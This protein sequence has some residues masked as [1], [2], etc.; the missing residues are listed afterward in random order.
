MREPTSEQKTAIESK[1]KTI[2]SASAGSGKTFVMIQKLVNSLIE[3][4]DIDRV[5]CVTFTKKAAAQMK[6]KLRSG[7]I[8]ALENLQADQ[9]RHLKSQLSKISTADISTIH[10]FLAKILRTYY[11]SLDIDA[12]FEL[13]ASDDSDAE[14]L[15][16][17][18][19]DSLFD[20]LYEENNPDFLFLLDRFTK[21]RSDR[22]LKK[23]I[24]EAHNSVRMLADYETL[25][26][27]WLDE[28]GEEQFKRVKEAFS[29]LA[30]D[31][32]LRL[33]AV[34]EKFENEFAFLSDNK[35]YTQIFDEMKAS[36]TVCSQRGVFHGISS[37]TS[38][39]K[40]KKKSGEDDPAGEV[41]KAF[42][43]DLDGKFKSVTKD[44]S[45]EAE[46]R[47]LLLKNTATSKAFCWL[48]LQFDREYALT[49]QEEN[50]LDYNDLEHFVLALLKDEQIK[51]EISAKYS[52]IYVDEYQDVN[53]IQEAII[54]RLGENVFFVGD[55]KQAIYGFRG[56][57]SAFFKDKFSEFK[58]EKSQ[59]LELSKNFRSTQSVLDFVNNV[60]SRIITKDFYGID[61]SPMFGGGNYPDEG[62]VAELCLYDDADEK[63]EVDGVYSVLNDSKNI[64]HTKEGLAVLALVKEELSGKHYDLEKGEFVPTKPSDICILTKKRANASTLGI[65]KALTDAGY[66]VSGVGSGDICT[67]PEV[68]NMIDIL[69]YLDNSLQ[70]I[71][72]VA[73]LM[74]P[75]GRLDE[76]ELAKIKI[77]SQNEKVSIAGGEKSRYLNFSECCKRY[78][79]V[80][81]DEIA[82]KL[83]EF[84]ARTER[85]K[86]L[87][88]LL[89]CDKIIDEILAV[90]GMEA[91]LSSGGG[92]KLKNVLSLADSARGMTVSQF[93]YKLRL[94]G[95]TIKSM[96][97][98]NSESIK[99]MTMHSSKG[100]EFPVVI[101][102][103]IAK[104]FEGGVSPIV[105]FDDKFGFAPKYYDVENKL[106][107][108][109]LLR[110]LEK[111]R[112][113]RDDVLNE[114]NLFYVAC[115]RAM[116]NLHILVSKIPKCTQDYIDN[117]SCYA[118][119]FDVDD[120]S[121]RIVVPC[122]EFSVQS[123]KRELDGK[124]DEQI[125]QAI[126]SRFMQEYS[127]SD[128]VML[129]VKSSATALLK[130]DDEQTFI[131][132][133]LFGGEG[134]TNTE[135]GTAYHRFL[136]L[137]DFSKT[138]GNAIESEIE[139][140]VSSGK[141]SDDNSRLLNAVQLERILN[142]PV[143]KG[144]SG[145]KLLREQ[146]FLCRLRACDV[147]E[148]AAEDNILIQG[149]I[150]LL[151]I[152]E[153]EIR[154]IDYK[155]ST[156]DDESLKRKYSKQLQ[157]YKSAVKTVLGG[158]RKINCTL[159][160]IYTCRQIDFSD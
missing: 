51:N 132:K 141:M 36:L 98:A 110:K 11:Y 29:A 5:L 156:L 59:A 108:D 60:F 159:L 81:K 21:K 52:E 4:G 160:N 129:P 64:T 74:S 85:L 117:A 153:N 2:V 38:I 53:P 72:L 87:L 31:K 106:K 136:E 125:K 145:L 37:L 111:A 56:S 126:E 46:E 114:V 3:G 154:I 24:F 149:A 73:A 97:A 121:P 133:Q 123:V 25:M 14:R 77:F 157:I 55:V 79:N 54:S 94:G 147:L 44:I 15:K 9:K 89:T 68:A 148:T 43:S 116:C 99:I 1:G 84:F 82:A 93:L 88:G 39:A 86:G 103:D 158:D 95:N 66:S 78:E 71:P 35:T 48:V 151:A 112:Q 8:S 83:K 144:I 67:L 63:E 18:A 91:E 27:N 12:A 109:T 142:M 139:E 135:K 143:F 119:M 124:V 23:L 49:K 42:K 96:Q 69:S 47:E 104:T 65:I 16:A 58:S 34:V 102:S 107:K 50:K 122:D 115:T 41:Y 45:S 120:L 140:F 131:P 130:Q 127:H 134:E 80:I 105:R 13:I 17:R 20:R 90:G 128:S 40:P 113:K 10:A 152:G 75:L 26:Q 101:I 138:T 76:E 7:I 146:E 70:D 30:S 22:H 100:L 92:D 32:F 57:K 62:A 6:E 150:D 19:I 61:Y 33:K 118:A 28:N 137:C 155:Y